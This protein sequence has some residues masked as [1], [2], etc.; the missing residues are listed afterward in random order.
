MDVVTKELIPSINLLLAASKCL[1]LLF[2]YLIVEQAITLLRTLT[3]KAYV[4]WMD[5]TMS[6][7]PNGITGQKIKSMILANGKF[8]LLANDAA[9]ASKWCNWEFGIGDAYK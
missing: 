4:D 9:I 8:I 5:E 6:E 3:A 7:K 2:S 1:R